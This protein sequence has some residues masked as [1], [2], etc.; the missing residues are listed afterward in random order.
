MDPS[1]NGLDADVF[2]LPEAFPGVLRA[3][4]GRKARSGWSAVV[5]LKDLQCRKV[6]L[7]PV[8]GE[9]SLLLRGRGCLVQLQ[10]D[11]DSISIDPLA[12][13][14]VIGGLSAIERGSRSLRP[15]AELYRQGG[16]DHASLGWTPQTLG[17]RNALVALDA[18][19]HGASH[20][21]VAEVIFGPRCV[22]Q[23]WSGGHGWMKSRIVRAL[24]KGRQ[25]M[26]GGYRDLLK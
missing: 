10:C 9:Q 21:E 13:S 20:R 15:L 23:D 7:D 24:R 6:I 18:A 4:V 5:S 11:G 22:T 19:S 26:E 25:L 12:I 1:L 2:W 8:G 17:L 3:H 14:L 16:R